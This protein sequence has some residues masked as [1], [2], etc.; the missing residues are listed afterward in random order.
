[1]I[2]PK[3]TIL[4]VDDEADL[5]ELIEYN[6]KREGYNVLKAENGAEGLR[7][8]RK[9]HPDLVLLDIMMPRMTGTDV[10]RAM[11]D[12]PELRGVPVIFLTARADEETEI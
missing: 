2:V 6:L 9:H 12:E 5:L 10:L 7:L 3:E 8:A 11:K 1:M 4:I